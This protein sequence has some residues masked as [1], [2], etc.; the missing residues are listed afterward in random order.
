MIERTLI[1]I[2]P[3]AVQRGIAGEI[4]ARF[5]RTGLKI[6]GI[7]MVKAS[8]ELAKKHYTDALIPIV[9]NKTKKD[10]DAAGI[11][12]TET[13]EQIGTMIVNS[14]RQMLTNHPVIA[15]CLEGIQ[16]VE[17]VRK[18]VGSTGCK[19]ALPGTIRGDYGHV[20]LG[21][22]SIKKRGIANL[23]HA[24][25]NP[26][27]AQQEITLWFAPHELQTYKSAHDEHI[28]HLNDW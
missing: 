4:L 7:K 25:G 14:I 6:V 5:E 28:L 15:L 3:D 8:Q 1:L 23:I 20:S 26:Q 13:P 17:N 24:S 19:D 22:A 2:K 21:Y 10:W 9:G 18:I 16:A 12:H 27:E 11:K